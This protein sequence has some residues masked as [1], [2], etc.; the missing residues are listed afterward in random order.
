MLL[1][2]PV[3]LGNEAH[4]HDCMVGLDVTAKWELLTRCNKPIPEP[5]NVDADLRPPTKMNAT[6]NPKYGF[7]ERFDRLLFTGT[8]EKMWY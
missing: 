3:A 4:H 8:I 2:V 6:V 1:N 7:V 5:N